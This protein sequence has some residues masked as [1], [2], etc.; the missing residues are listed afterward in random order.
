MCQ[1]GSA[2][3]LYGCPEHLAKPVVVQP[4]LGIKAIMLVCVLISF[5]TGALRS[6]PPRPIGNNVEFSLAPPATNAFDASRSDPRRKV[7]ALAYV[8]YL[9]VP[10]PIDHAFDALARYTNAASHRQEFEL[11]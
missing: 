10:A 2:Y 3:M 7:P 4:L 9:K 11:Q 6:S 8:K 1:I 5:K